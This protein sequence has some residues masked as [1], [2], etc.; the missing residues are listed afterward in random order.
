MAS[1]SHVLCFLV[2]GAL[3]EKKRYTTSTLSMTRPEY[4][5]ASS[6]LDVPPRFFTEINSRLSTFVLG[7]NI[8]LSFLREYK[9]SI[10]YRINQRQENAQFRLLGCATKYDHVTCLRIRVVTPNSDAHAV[11]HMI[12][13]LNACALKEKRLHKNTGGKIPLSQSNDN[14]YHYSNLMIEKFSIDRFL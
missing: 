12:V 6:P 7:I 13:R 9:F 8:G 11:S 5:A 10:H 2:C 4:Q 1:P 3:L 14:Y